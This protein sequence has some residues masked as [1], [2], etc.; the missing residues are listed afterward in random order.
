M[1]I[2]EKFMVG[3]YNLLQLGC[4]EY[5]MNSAPGGI[6]P[7]RVLRNWLLMAGLALVA[8]PVTASPTREMAI[9]GWVENAWLTDPPLMVK[10][11]LDS[12]AETSSLHAVIIKKFRKGGKRWVRFQVE[13]SVAGEAHTLVRER[14]RTIGVMQHDGDTQT[15]PVVKMEVCLNGRT[16][17]T[18][19]SLTDRSHF[20]Y[21][22]LLGRNT[23]QGFFLIDPANTF[24]SAE[25]CAPGPADAEP[26]QVP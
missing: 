20:N 21:P 22:L 9:L 6:V 16:M 10:A 12:G 2:Y 23:L 11:K 14:V 18:E 8:Y 15:R 19:V 26:G 24:L 17:E 13:D 3:R 1:D 4:D 25:T 5:A 7:A